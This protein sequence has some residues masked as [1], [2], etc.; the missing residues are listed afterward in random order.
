MEY[1]RLKYSSTSTYTAHFDSLVPPSS[2][3]C[4]SWSDTSSGTHWK[5]VIASISIIVLANYAIG[6]LALLL[7]MRLFFKGIIS[8]IS[9]IS[10]K[11]DL[12]SILREM[13]EAKTEE[14]LLKWATS[15]SISEDAMCVAYQRSHVN[16]LRIKRGK[17]DFF[18]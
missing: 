17:A 13:L 6:G 12:N 18:Q 9:A 8:A 3:I 14:E 11:A 1:D 5:Q 7:Q 2:F 16:F 4:T 15:E 10:P